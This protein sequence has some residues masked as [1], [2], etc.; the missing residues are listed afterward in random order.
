V[1]VLVNAVS[2]KEGGPRVVLLRLLQHMQAVR[3]DTDWCV[4][5]SAEIAADLARIPRL[6]QR[7]VAVDRSP[8]ALV[9]WYEAGL[10]A[11]ARHWHADVVFSVTNYLPFRAMRRPTLLLEQHAGH[12]S[13]EFDRLTREAAPSILGRGL[14]ALKSGWVRRSVKAATVL[15]V[16]THALADAIST[17][18][19]RSQNSIHVTPHGPGWVE[20]AAMPRS[21]PSGGKWRIGYITKY[22]VQKNFVTL[23]QALATLARDGFPVTL[24]LTLDPAHAPV[25]ALLAQARAMG[26]ADL[27]ENRG[28][29][30][31]ESVAAL[32]DELDVFAF[33]SLCESFGMPMVEAM[34]RGLPIVVADTPVNREI[35]G[36]AGL[37]FPVFDADALAAVLGTLMAN[38][39]KR[40]AYAARSLTRAQ[41]FSWEQAAVSTLAALDAAAGA[42]LG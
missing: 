22:G 8:H 27:I 19:G 17:V 21:H 31:G 3:S 37:V 4:A 41:A 28:E 12:F 26:I 14:W 32:Y 16:Q 5:A 39:E 35:T 15:A 42:R 6:T 29:V 2:I 10:T 40:Q 20:R 9:G 23:F 34:A 18:T 30:A 24:V 13:A 7:A 1:R 33:P 38:E 25:P 11:M 36:E